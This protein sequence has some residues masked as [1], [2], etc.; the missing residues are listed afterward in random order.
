MVTKSFN[1][2]QTLQSKLGYTD[3]SYGESDLQE[4]IEKAHRR[5]ETL[6]GRKQTDVIRFH[7]RDKDGDYILE[8]DLQMRPILEFSHVTTGNT[9]VDPSVYEVDEETG[10]ITFT[11]EFADDYVGA[12]GLGVRRT[13]AE[14]VYVP[15]HYK[16][17]EYWL[18]VK[19]MLAGSIVQIDEDQTNT[20][21]EQ[22][23]KE[24]H[25]LQK[26]INRSRVTGSFTDGVN[27]RGYR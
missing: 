22:A 6:V 14:A 9:R 27:V 16:D 2:P 13:E 15:K 20:T 5:L 12:Q 11:Q 25:K 21:V 18:A 7:E 17:L 1:N 10:T 23:Q 19:E 3:D 8:K 26:M 4:V 24:V